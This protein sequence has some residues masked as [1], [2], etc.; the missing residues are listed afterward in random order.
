MT[1]LSRYAGNQLVGRSDYGN[2]DGLLTGLVHH[3]GQTIF[4][5]YRWTYDGGLSQFSSDDNGTVPLL[6]QSMLPVHATKGIVEALQNGTYTA[7]LLTDMLSSDGSVHYTYDSTGQLIGA[8]YTGG[9]LPNESYQW[10]ANGN[11]A[12]SG[13]LV[14]LDNRLLSDGTYRYE[15]D[16]EGNRVARFIDSD[17]SGTLTE[18]DTDLMAYTWDNRN[19]LTEIAHR[20]V[21][22][23]AVDWTA[24][25]IY[26]A[27]NHRIGSLY[28]N[29]GDGTIDREERYAWEGKNVVL[30]FVDS[31]GAT[32]GE[33]SAPL[34]LAAR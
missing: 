28:D 7:V 9:K 19:R 24:D 3:Q 20:A 11:P 33:K 30:D 5:N 6:S 25:Y 10:D 27:L 4:A 12:G 2:A 23:K 18:G 16:A 34:A 8:T 14:G 15:Y 29:N 17:K 22:G 21:F 1:F 31:D 26:D 13:Y 32:G